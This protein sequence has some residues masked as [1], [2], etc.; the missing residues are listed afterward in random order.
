M[1]AGTDCRICRLRLAAECLYMCL[2]RGAA[3]LPAGSRAGKGFERQWRGPEND[4]RVANIWT[5]SLAPSSPRAVKSFMASYPA[6]RP[7]GL[8]FANS[9]S[10]RWLTQGRVLREAATEFRRLGM[11]AL[12]VGCGGGSYAIENHLRQG[13]PAML[14]DFDAD[15]VTMSRRR[16]GVLFAS[17]TAC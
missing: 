15:V 17:N 5:D 12:D 8:E 3:F 7:L 2:R 13:T 14:C 10:V 9:Q 1:T 16:A 11:R 4:P 6:N